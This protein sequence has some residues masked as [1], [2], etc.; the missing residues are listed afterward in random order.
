M[1]VEVGCF[2]W[3]C[4]TPFNPAGSS[5]NSSGRRKEA[6]RHPR[7]IALQEPGN[8]RPSFRPCLLSSPLL[9]L[10]SRR[11]VIMGIGQV[12]GRDQGDLGDPNHQN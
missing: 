10:L 12:G 7:L 3:L 4:L 1:E 6:E 8:I 9:G 5:G 11:F 2:G